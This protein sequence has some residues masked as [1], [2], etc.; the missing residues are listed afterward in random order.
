MI[1]PNLRNNLKI[2][3]IQSHVLVMNLMRFMLIIIYGGLILDLQ[4]IFQ[5]PCKVCE[6]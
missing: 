6:T 3:V 2:T 4:S 1:A 5:I